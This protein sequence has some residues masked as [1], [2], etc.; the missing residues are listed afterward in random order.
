MDGWIDG[1]SCACI[2]EI[3]PHH[4]EIAEEMYLTPTTYFMVILKD[5]SSKHNS[6]VEVFNE[7]WGNTTGKYC[8]LPLTI[9]VML[10]VILGEQHTR[11]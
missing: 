4:L 5:N 3:L 6:P 11:T 2:N 8:Q 1:W 10:L 9:S 7:V